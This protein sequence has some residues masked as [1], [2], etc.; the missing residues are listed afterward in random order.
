[1]AAVFYSTGISPAARSVNV[2]QCEGDHG[3]KTGGAMTSS[4]IRLG[5]D[6]LLAAKSFREWIQEGWA[7]PA[8]VVELSPGTAEAAEAHRGRLSAALPGRRIAVAAGRPVGPVRRHL[9]PVSRRQRLRLAD[10]LPARRRGAGA[11]PGRERRP[12]R[13]ST[14]P[15]RRSPARTT[16]WPMRTPARCESGPCPARPPTARH[17]ASSAARR[18]TSRADCGAGTL[19]RLSSSGSIPFSTL[20]DTATAQHCVRSLRSC[21]ASKMRGRCAS[22]RRL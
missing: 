5:V 7:T 20:S 9:P 19:P 21:D 18:R 13:S 10:G 2:D 12:M 6:A 11:D 17:P 22:C 15:A 14:S 1:M 4:G 3:N 8:N 16:S